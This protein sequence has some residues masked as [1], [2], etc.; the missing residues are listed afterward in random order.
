MK[1]DIPYPVIDIEKTGSNIQRL[2]EK[3][4]LSVAEVQHFLGLSDP[5]AIYQWQRGS[6]LPSVDHLCALSKLLRVTIDEILI[7]RKSNGFDR[8]PPPASANNIIAELLR[9]HM[10]PS[11]K[12]VAPRWIKS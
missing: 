10:F 9:Q 12:H 6:T 11:P 8:T 4:G 7:L 1:Y 5:Q 3:R 2:R